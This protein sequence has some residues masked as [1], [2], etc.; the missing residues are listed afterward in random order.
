MPFVAH[1]QEQQPQAPPTTTKTTIENPWFI[2][3]AFGF[4]F[5]TEGNYAEF[6][7]IIG[8]Q[9]SPLFQVGGSLTFRYRKDKRYEPDLSTTDIGASLL[10]RFYVWGPVFLQG[11]VE[12]I[13]WE[14]LVREED[15][16]LVT[17]ESPYTGLYAGAGFALETSP[18]SAMY[19]TFLW[20]FNHESDVPNPNDNPF[21]V[22]IG[23]GFRF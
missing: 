4:A 7:P 19:M 14:Y 10:A 22:R 1:A 9:I 13:N 8:Y 12:R 2:G 16:D 11:E 6:S 15:G 20:D 21:I 18:R 23:Y 5:G 17:V 3:G